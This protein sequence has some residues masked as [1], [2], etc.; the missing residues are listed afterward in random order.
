MSRPGAGTD[1]GKDRKYCPLVL[2]AS[3]PCILH[4]NKDSETE[5]ESRGAAAYSDFASEDRMA[6]TR[7][8][9]L[10]GALGGAALARAQEPPGVKPEQG[11]PARK[12]KVVRLFKAP[13]EHPNALE[14]TRDALWIGGQVTEKAYKVDWKTGK[15]LHEVQ[16]DSHN[17][18]GIAVGGGYLWMSANGRTE[19]RPPRPTDNDFDEIFQADLET[20][21]T[22]RRYR[23]PWPGGSHGIAYVEQT[24]T[25]WVTAL[26]IKAL[27]EL[28]WKDNFRVLR[29]IP[30]QHDRAHG[31]DWDNGAMWV[32]FSSDYVIHK[33]DATTGKV[34]EVV[35]LAKGQDPDPHGMCF[36]DGHLYYCDAGLVVGGVSNGSPSAGYVCRIDL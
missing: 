25:L 36:H 28:D 7:R 6:T 35:T 15:V 33:V 32:L 16:T 1:H 20:G 14:A 12:A 4:P 9:F 29:V 5:P 8:S 19:R 11:V 34:L 30:V 10:A 21:K 2:P 3:A 23:P 22:I 13:D 18:S 31:I 17:T 24:Q 26:G 27:A